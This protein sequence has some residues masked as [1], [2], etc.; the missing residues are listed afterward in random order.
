[1]R[2]TLLIFTLIMALLLS[3]CSFSAGAEA[4]FSLDAK[5]VY[6]DDTVNLEISGNT[7]ARYGQ[8]ISVVVYEINSPDNALTAAP[9]AEYPLT[10]IRK[11]VRM[12]EITAAY[13]GDYE[14][15]LSFEGVEDAKYF[16]I[17]VT[18]GG[19]KGASTSASKLIYYENQET[20]DSVTL[21]AFKSA[22]AEEIDSLLKTKQLLLGYYCDSDYEA[23][24]DDIAS[25][26]VSIR[27]EDYTENFT[28]IND[29]QD[30][31]SKV[32]VLRVI[33]TNPAP[34][35]MQNIAEGN[36][37]VLT[38]DFTDTD[39]TKNKEGVY[40]MTE[41][42]M[43]D[44]KNLPDSM[45]DVTRILRQATGMVLLNG[46]D[47]TQMTDTVKKYADVFGIEKTDYE[48]AC[49]E[50]GAD[51]VNMAFVERNFTSPAKVLEAY[52]ECVGVLKEEEEETSGGNGS[53][54]S[55]GG[56][57]FSG[58]GGTITKAEIDNDIVDAGN[59]DETTAISYND[60]NENHW[61][62]E[63]ILHLSEKGI[64][65]GMG[66]G[67]FA[68]NNTVTREQFVKIIVEA[69][70]IEDAD[71][72]NKFTDVEN[73]RWSQDYIAIA[74]GA[75]VVSGVG[76]GMFAPE[77]PVTRQDAAVMLKRVCDKYQVKLESAEKAFADEDRVASYAID[78]VKALSGAGIINGFEDGTFRPADTLTR[79]Q[80]A[81]LI[82]G[83][84]K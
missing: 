58:G 35:E 76:E 36:K 15:A 79:A 63:S 18:G 43:S 6:G 66:D 49:E 11:I 53:G 74:S 1:M 5:L 33:R 84:I 13:N 38:Y 25:L 57:G 41:I 78:S 77:N 22:S 9:A 23:G 17:Q 24:K 20:I 30:V 31:L 12:D 62:F 42:I 80:A 68:P 83:L 34:S 37:A 10:D 52:K 65:N 69:F 44:V 7:S 29:V 54:G 55:G 67:S 59:V 51:R 21:P 4:P 50:F 40:E 60:V 73:G 27:D 56:G 61:A 32:E 28:T 8:I 46:M 19:Y 26:F 82:Y 45:T 72:K 70:G 64:L 81:K 2:K 16:V 14:A 3:V 75:G 47:A 71:I 48:E 39:Y